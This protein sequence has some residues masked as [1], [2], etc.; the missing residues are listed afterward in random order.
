MDGPFTA[1]AESEDGI[2]WTKPNLGIHEYD[3]SK[4]NNLVWMGPGYNMGAFRDDNPDVHEDERYKAL[5]RN[6]GLLA[7]ASPDGLH[8][9]LMQEEPVMTEGPFDS[10]NIAFWDSWRNEYVAYARGV[11]GMGTGSGDLV[12][13]HDVGHFKR[14][15]AKGGV[16]WIRRATSK[17]FI[18][19]VEA[20]EHRPRATRPSSTSTPARA[21]STSGRRAPT[22]CSRRASSST[23]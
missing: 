11:G 14:D 18:S 22:S 3:G 5:V 8:W 23:G 10:H 9:R 7:L 17:D 6:G 20:R 19:W 2:H 13:Y 12:Y 21:S 15:A 4:D 1:Y 16:R